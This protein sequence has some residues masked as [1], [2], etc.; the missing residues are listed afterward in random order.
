MA[1]IAKEAGVGSATM[2]RHF[3]A[4]RDLIEAVLLR[5]LVES[6]DAVEAALAAADPVE[7]L[8]ELLAHFVQSLV[9][10]RRLHQLAGQRLM[11]RRDVQ[12]RRTGVIE[13]SG[14]VLR[15]CQEIGRVGSDVQIMD[16][17][18]LTEGIAAASGV[19]GWER[20]L[21]IVL[22]GISADR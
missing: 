6:E 7:G 14:I 9:R 1:A 20:L 4:K 16:L 18:T 15:R 8:A 10:D 3:P 11:E 19:Q 13:G 17:L 12:D 2:F 22:R 21:A 5:C